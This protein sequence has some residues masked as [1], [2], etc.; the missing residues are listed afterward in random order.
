MSFCLRLHLPLT[1][2][3]LS[4]NDVKKHVILTDDIHYAT[5]QVIALENTL[6]GGIYPQH[7]ILEIAA[8]A[9]HHGMKMHLD[10]ARLWHVGVE[11]GQ[12][13]SELCAPFDTVSLCFS[14]GLGTSLLLSS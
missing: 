14:K 2:R 3:Y 1:G 12:P 13:L 9:K 6:N 8:F 11:T 4:L 10:G 7:S 5:T